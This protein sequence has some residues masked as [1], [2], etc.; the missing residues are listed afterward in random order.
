MKR[1]I[2]ESPAK[3][4]MVILVLAVLSLS[5]IAPLLLVFS[6]SMTPEAEI[7]KNGYHFIPEKFSTEAYTFIFR[8]SRSL[9]NS[10]VVTIT[11]TAIGTLL[12][13][14]IT[15]MAAYA[16][17]RKDVKYRNVIAMYMFICMLFNGGLVASYLLVTRYLHLKNTLWA[18]I[19]PAMVSPWYILLMRNFFSTGV[20]TEIIESA[21]VDGIGEFGAFVRIVVPISKPTFATIG[22]FLI[23]GYWNDWWLSLLYIDVRNLYSLQYTLQS[24]LLNIQA[25]MSNVDAQRTGAAA[26]LPSESARMA[27]CMLS[28]GPIILAYPLLQKYLVKG[29]T[30]GAVKG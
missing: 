15:S 30:V 13:L 5:C 1:N 27:L 28:I 22:L 24:I 20:P 3:M 4:I 9:L 11:V 25:I 26:N 17:S 29:M 16:M 2:G 8:N 10:Y 6:V 21:K 7:A 19:L 14:A 18:L 23:L 12:G